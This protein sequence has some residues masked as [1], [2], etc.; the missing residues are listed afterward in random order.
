MA[1]GFLKIRAAVLFAV[2]IVVLYASVVKA[3]EFRIGADGGVR[4]DG[5]QFADMRHYV[6]SAYFREN[7]KRCGV[8]MMEGQDGRRARSASHCT[9]YLTS[10][11]QE[12]WPDIVFR[13]PVWWHV[14]N[15]SDGEGRLSDAVIEAQM[16]A[17]NEDYR[18]KSGTPGSRGFDVKIEFELAGIERRVSDEWF[19]DSEVTETAFK[20][21]L[22]KDPDQYINI[23]TNDG[24]GF[25]GYTYLP[26]GSAGE[27]ED[28]I[29]LNYA[30]VGGRDNAF[31]PYNQGR[32]LVHE[33]G[34]YLGLRHTF[35]NFVC[36]N[37][38]TTADLIVDTAAENL[39]HYGCEQTSTCGTLDPIHNYMDYSDDRCMYLFTREQ[40]NRTVCSLVNYRPGLFSSQGII[41]PLLA[42]ILLN[43][44]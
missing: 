12:Y 5:H 25:L 18:A 8:R 36:S 37:T 2:G 32:T 41:P 26:D 30:A 10:I 33:M 15:R 19:V 38:Y 29:V 9:N 39:P 27:W 40:A 16:E 43:K 23:Y 13:V 35:L 6:Q 14:I 28:G 17:L 34:H 44:E 21:A 1:Y 7:G 3:E 20:K 31:Y 24:G 11:R 22:A 4:V 42:P